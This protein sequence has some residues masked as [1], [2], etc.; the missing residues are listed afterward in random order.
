MRGERFDDGPGAQIGTT[1]AQAQKDVGLLA[2][3]GGRSVDVFQQGIVRL[4]QQVAPAE[5]LVAGTG[6]LQ[7][8]AMSGFRAWAD[9]LQIVRF[10]KR[11]GGGEIVANHGSVNTGCGL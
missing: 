4:Q 10:E 7:Q 2:D 1:D 11:Q 3:L 9:G 5:H 8:H 6:T